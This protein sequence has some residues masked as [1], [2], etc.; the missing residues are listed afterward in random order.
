MI[1]GFPPCYF[2]NRPGAT[3]GKISLL[4]TIYNHKDKME[5]K[6]DIPVDPSEPTSTETV[7]LDQ[8]K[9]KNDPVP[10]EKQ[11]PGPHHRRN[12]DW[13]TLIMTSFFHVTRLTL[14]AVLVAS[15][16]V[17]GHFLLISG[18][19]SCDTTAVVEARLR[20]SMFSSDLV[21]PGSGPCSQG[22]VRHSLSHTPMDRI[23]AI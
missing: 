22:H 8:D 12:L 21:H 17:L 14:R 10:R 16:L 13:F 5:D 1:G 11:P 23:C 7:P 15:L 19:L 20:V 9:T 6:D 18:E 2:G 4:Y 3:L